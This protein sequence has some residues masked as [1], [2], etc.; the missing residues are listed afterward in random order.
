MLETAIA[1]VTLT[2]LILYALMGGADYGGGFW[3]LFASGPRANRQR[4]HI[5]DAI[6]PI[7]EANHVWL[8]LVIVLLFTA[9][10]PAFAAMMT[11]LHIPL[12]AMLIGIVLRGSAFIFRK[13]DLKD[14]RVQR[15]WNVVFGV[16]SVVTPFLQ[17]LCLGALAS[18]AIG[19]DRAM[20]TTGFFAGW[21]GPFAISCGVFAVALFAF[22]AA[23]YLTVE[24]TADPEVQNDFRRRALAAEVALAPIAAAV[25]FAARHGG[26]EDMYAGLT[27]WWAPLLLGLTSA[28]ALLALAG[29]WTRRFRLARIGA[30][31]QVTLILV[32][33]S[34]A[35]FPHL[36]VPDIDFF[37]AAAPEITLRLLAIALAVGAV[38]LL[39]SLYY[40]FRVFKSSRLPVPDEAARR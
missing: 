1:L 16:S 21:T 35:Q 10:P 37:E 12:T 11:A 40:L 3:D 19:V 8:I 17:G 32:G 27:H 24:A 5:A 39:P 28:F 29:L 13:Y 38:I 34:V 6:A 25:F 33:W 36:I 22:L 31:G 23:V 14:D 2:S 9:F 7:W 4:K 26:A 18:G 30:I 15:R 20:V